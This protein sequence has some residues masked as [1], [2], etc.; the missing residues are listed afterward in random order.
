L[1]NKPLPEFLK[2]DFLADDVLSKEQA[3]LH[4]WNVFE[5]LVFNKK[6]DSL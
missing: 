2:A 4:K 6:I 1:I 3:K 5:Q